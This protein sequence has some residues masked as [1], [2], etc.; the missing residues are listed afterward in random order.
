VRLGILGN[1]PAAHLAA[2]AARAAGAEVLWAAP[3]R[4]DAPA[5]AAHVHILRPEIVA[6]I[7]RVDPALGA[8]VAAA[9]EPAH[10]WIAAD[11]TRRLAPRLTRARLERALAEACAA[12]GLAPDPALDPLGDPALWPDPGRLWI[13]ATGA[14]RV[15]AR[16]ADALGLGVLALDDLGAG[17]LWQTR[18]WPVALP[19][20]PF[21]WVSPG[22]LYVQADRHETRATGP[23][24]LTDPA[25]VPLPPGLP[26]VVLKMA[27][28]PVRLA[29]F[30][31]GC[32]VLLLGDARLQTPPA[33]GFGLLGSVQQA[34]VLAHCL[35]T[36]HDPEAAL[37]DWAEG[38]WM[39][40]GLAGALPEVAA[41]D[42]PTCP[43]PPR[44]ADALFRSP[45]DER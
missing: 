5:Q 2:L 20:A 4:A 18:H 17:Q 10:P 40:A 14:Q 15:L 44:P 19:V 21:T 28:P 43:A 38:M 35:R 23:V 31:G 24:G 41:P 34:G 1:G 25:A 32:P 33:M 13:D 27:G 45:L 3:P 9:V 39:G 8:R 16:R 42:Q 22:R 36:G 30:E 6:G 12:A 26:P 37:A 7:A 11:G 29:R